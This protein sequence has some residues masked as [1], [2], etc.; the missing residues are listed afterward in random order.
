MTGKKL[1]SLVEKQHEL[2]KSVISPLCAIHAHAINTDSPPMAV[3]PHLFIRS[4]I[5]CGKII[6]KVSESI[7]EN[8]LVELRGRYELIRFELRYCNPDCRFTE[9][10]RLIAESTS[11][12]G[13]RCPQMPAYRRKAQNEPPHHRSASAR[14]IRWS[15]PEY[16]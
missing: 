16:R 12:A 14:S 5:S 15:V 7:V 8:G 13:H 3:M 2:R 9:L 1:L 4:A 6:E 11:A 10:R